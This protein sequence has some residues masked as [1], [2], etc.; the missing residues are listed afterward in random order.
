MASGRV[1]DA[2]KAVAEK[3]A[4]EVINTRRRP[5]PPRGINSFARLSPLAQRQT[6]REGSARVRPLQLLTSPSS[7][8]GKPLTYPP[9]PIA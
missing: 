7:A 4:D 9:C 3:R 1:A 6:E 5:S 8:G 2:V